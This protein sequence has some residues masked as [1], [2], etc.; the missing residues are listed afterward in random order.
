MTV[1]VSLPEDKTEVINLLMNEL[2]KIAVETHS[3]E[4]IL[5]LIDYLKKEK[6]AGR[7]N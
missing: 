3:E 6:E 4:E 2:G 1:T 5:A 7:L